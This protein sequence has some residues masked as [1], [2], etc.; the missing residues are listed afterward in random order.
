MEN[1]GLFEWCMPL[2]TSMFHFVVHDRALKAWT[3]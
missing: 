2:E 3:V 1:A